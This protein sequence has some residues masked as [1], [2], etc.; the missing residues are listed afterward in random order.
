[1]ASA[2]VSEVRMSRIA[3][4]AF[5]LLMSGVVAGACSSSPSKSAGPATS[6]AAATTSSTT[7]A[8]PPAGRA[9]PSDGCTLLTAGEVASLLGSTPQCTARPTS[10]GDPQVASAV[11]QATRTGPSAEV[12]VQRT[13]NPIS[14]AVFEEDAG[15]KSNAGAK[16]VT[17]LGDDAVL[18]RR[19]PSDPSGALWILAGGDEFQV[20]DTRGSATGQA[21]DN[22]LTTIGR[23]L[24]GSYR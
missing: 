20:I 16:V 9:L 12:A 18:I 23:R 4:R 19:S 11:W 3:R 17:G 2:S 13:S 22:A 8:Q 10:A 5:L 14:K 24:L 1:M 7:S 15:T 6:P 21:L